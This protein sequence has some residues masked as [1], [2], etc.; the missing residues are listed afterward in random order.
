[1][2]EEKKQFWLFKVDGDQ[3]KKLGFKMSENGHKAVEKTKEAD[4]AIADKNIK[5]ERPEAMQK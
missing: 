5:G 1:M 2:T 3:W 4:L